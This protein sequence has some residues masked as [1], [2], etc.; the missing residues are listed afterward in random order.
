M[1]EAKD[2]QAPRP[3]VDYRSP[4]ARPGQLFPW[5]QGEEWF[6]WGLLLASVLVGF[7]MTIFAPT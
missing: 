5:P 4:A 1:S 3:V 7:G 2:E 6:W